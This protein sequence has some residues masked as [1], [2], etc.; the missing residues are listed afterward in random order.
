MTNLVS[1]MRARIF[2]PFCVERPLCDVSWTDRSVVS[3]NSPMASCD[4]GAALATARR[5]E[6]S[7]NAFIGAIVNERDLG[8]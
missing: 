7:V 5:V 3:K 8:V 6:L 4:E 2:T 1:D